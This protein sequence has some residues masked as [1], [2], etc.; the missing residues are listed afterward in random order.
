MILYAVVDQ[1]GQKALFITDREANARA[2]A[3][4]EKGT[5]LETENVLLSDVAKYDIAADYEEDCVR[6]SV[7]ITLREKG[8]DEDVD[9]AGFEELAASIASDAYHEMSKYGTSEDYE[10]D[11]AMKAHA[12]EVSALLAKS[13]TN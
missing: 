6:E 1:K 13:E 2:I 9:P 4:K 8:I 10:I 5:V 12:A 3:E 11:E 7:R